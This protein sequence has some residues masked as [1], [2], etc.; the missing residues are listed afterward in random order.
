MSILAS[1]SLSV[2]VWQ[3]ILRHAIF[4]PDFLDPDSFEGDLK[5]HGFGD[6]CRHKEDQR[7][8]WEAERTRKRLGRVCKSWRGY[9]SLFEHRF[10]RMSDIWHHR[11]EKT[12]ILRATRI[13]VAAF[14]CACAEV[15]NGIPELSSRFSRFCAEIVRESRNL[16]VEILQGFD[17]SAQEV[18][19]AQDFEFLGRLQVVLS[20][21]NKNNR[22]PL[23]SQIPTLRNFWPGVSIYSEYPK[24]HLVFKSLVTL[25]YMASSTTSAASLDWDLPSLRHL[26]IGYH[27][28]VKPEEFTSCI[29]LPMLRLVGRQLRSLYID[30]LGGIH[31]PV[32]DLWGLCPRVEKIDPGTRVHIP[33]PPNHPVHTLSIHSQYFSV[34]LEWPNLRRIIFQ[35]PWMWIPTEVIDMLVRWSESKKMCTWSLEDGQ[36]EYWDPSKWKTSQ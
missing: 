21:I 14:Q 19:D 8:Y 17:E 4:V 1:S 31:E 23:M 28:S 11:I 10:V 36:G 26:S 27:G 13:N 25:L 30:N 35:S 15:C 7:V 24:K 32:V 29:L 6:E 3:L 22:I 16:P 12:A 9:L 5:R 20:L 18:W 34:D 33:P 2:E